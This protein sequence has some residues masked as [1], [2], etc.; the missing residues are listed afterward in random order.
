MPT[1]AEKILRAEREPLG[2]QEVE[3]MFDEIRLLVLEGDAAGLAAKVSE[4]SQE[5]REPDD[6]E[7]AAGTERP[8]EPP[9][10]AQPEGA[11]PP[12]G[13]ARSA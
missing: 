10:P 5:L 13:G 7:A 9:A 2:V 4:L 11:T 6:G 1:E 8:A 12:A 3:S